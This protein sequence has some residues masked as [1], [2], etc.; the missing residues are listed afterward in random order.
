[1]SRVIV[2][3]ARIPTTIVNVECKLG[4]TFRDGVVSLKQFYSGDCTLD[5]RDSFMYWDELH[6]SEQ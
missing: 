2:I 6:P 1:M 3:N 5:Q 4:L